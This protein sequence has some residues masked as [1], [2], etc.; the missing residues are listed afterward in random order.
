MSA[1]YVRRHIRNFVFVDA[2]NKQS[3]VFE[4]LN[5]ARCYCAALDDAGKQV[6]AVDVSYGVS[7]G[8][9]A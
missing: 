3:E 6:F 5:K 9:S 4:I 1:N 2:R 7:S 8:L